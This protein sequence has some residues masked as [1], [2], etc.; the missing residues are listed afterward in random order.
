MPVCIAG[1]HGLFSAETYLSQDALLKDGENLGQILHYIY[2]PAC[3]KKSNN[4]MMY[5][6]ASDTE[7]LSNDMMMFGGLLI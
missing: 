6:R 1:G 5:W 3:M 4:W 7:E 2:S